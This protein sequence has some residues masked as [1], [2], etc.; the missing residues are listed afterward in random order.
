M[1]EECNCL[2]LKQIL[3]CPFKTSENTQFFQN[4]FRTGFT[5]SETYWPGLESA[6]V[7]GCK[8]VGQSGTAFQC[9][10]TDDLSPSRELFSQPHPSFHLG[11]CP[12]RIGGCCVLPTVP[13]WIVTQAEGTSQACLPYT[14]VDTY[15]ALRLCS[16]P[17]ALGV[18]AFLTPEL[19]AHGWSTSGKVC[20]A[21]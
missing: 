2:R 8:N 17:S 6:G 3:S 21:R 1:T 4:F 18:P 12:S 16:V 19:G 13:R 5:A 15:W 11:V 20:L 9:L 14:C 7:L 10:E